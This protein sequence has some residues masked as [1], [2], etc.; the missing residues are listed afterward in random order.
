MVQRDKVRSGMRSG[1]GKEW[2]GDFCVGCKVMG[3]RSKLQA[4]CVP[5]ARKLEHERRRSS[6]SFCCVLAGA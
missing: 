4:K 1:R 5:W 6:L 2:K 3:L